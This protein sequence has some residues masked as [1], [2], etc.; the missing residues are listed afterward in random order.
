MNDSMR[1]YEATRKVPAEAKKPIPAGRLK[2]YT[3]INPMWRIKTMT[4][5]FGICGIGWKVELTK[6]WLE[7]YSTGETAAFCNIN[8]YIKV[9][10]EWSEAIPGTGGAMYVVKERNGMYVDDEAFKK[11]ETDAISVACKMLGIGADVYWGEDRT[12]YDYVPEEPKREQK[13]SDPARGELLALIKQAYPDEKRLELACQKKF[14]KRFGQLTTDEMHEV[15]ALIEV[16]KGEA[17]GISGSG[18][19]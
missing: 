18:A 8:L 17:K 13:P 7:P 15:L 6:Q 4:E 5:Q 16:S 12:K 11:A 14:N 2:G 9:V 19:D 10:G 1:I 3:N